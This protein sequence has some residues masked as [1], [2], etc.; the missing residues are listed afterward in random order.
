MVLNHAVS[1]TLNSLSAVR[2]FHLQ[3][4]IDLPT[5]NSYFPLKEAIR[6]ARRYLQ[7][8]TIQKLPIYPSLLSALIGGTG[9]GSPWR[10]LYLTLWLTFARLASL[11]PMGPSQRF[12]LASHLSWG[13]VVFYRDSVQII[14]TKTKTIQ[15]S[16]RYL[17]F[18][19]P[20][21]AN[22]SICLYSQLREWKANSP[23]SSSNDPVFIIFHQGQWQ[24]LNRSLADPV[25]KAAL[26]ALG[27]NPLH[28]GWSSFRRG[29]ATAGFIATGD[30]ESLR[31]HG[32]WR[33][34]AY[35]R[36]L[37]LP[38]NKIL[39]LVNALQDI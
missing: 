39:G 9:W 18:R 3:S 35:T 2:R 5:P 27:V 32:D 22:Q 15:C 36:F 28:Y 10:C 37:A 4:G 38:A 19:I 25:F 33:S 29:G 24:P 7:R 23:F 17:Q 1:T 16:E 13:N 8:P 20:K 31:E 11:I 21:H 6:G 14:F 12:D 26:S 30:V 34:Y